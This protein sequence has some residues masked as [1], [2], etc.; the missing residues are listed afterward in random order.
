MRGSRKRLTR[1]STQPEASI[2]AAMPGNYQ[3]SRQATRSLR[4]N[5]EQLLSEQLQPA[6]RR[7]K[8]NPMTWF[9][10]FARSFHDIANMVVAFDVEHDCFH[11]QVGRI[12]AIC[13]LHLVEAYDFVDRHTHH[14]L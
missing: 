14:L 1:Y 3:H 8:A 11:H 13:S 12:D 2:R 10:R 6:F 7:V 4:R 5:T 9:I